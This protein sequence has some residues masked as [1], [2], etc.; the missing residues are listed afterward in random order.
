[1]EEASFVVETLVGDG[2]GTRTRN[3]RAVTLGVLPLDYTVT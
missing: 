1:M 2:G 3:S